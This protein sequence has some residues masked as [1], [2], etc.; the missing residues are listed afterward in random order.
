[1]VQLMP[2]PLHD[3]LLVVVVVVVNKVLW[4]AITN[5]KYHAVCPWW[6]SVCLPHEQVSLQIQVIYCTQRT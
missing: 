1:M 4:C 2:L 6:L 3:L 5:M